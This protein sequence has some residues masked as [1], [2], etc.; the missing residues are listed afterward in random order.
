M[1]HSGSKPTGPWASCPRRYA[2]TCCG[3]GWSQGDREFFSTP[4]MLGAFDLAGVGRSPSRFDFVKLENMNG[5]YLRQTDNRTLVDTLVATLPYLPE[6]PRAS[7]ALD[8]AMRDKLL[9]AMPGLKERA[10]T[11]V[12]LLDGAQFLFATRPLA[13]DAKAEDILGKGGRAVLAGL[14]PA[15]DAVE[16]WTA[17]DIEAVVRS[18]AET[19]GLK[20][21]Q[22]AQ[23]LAGRRDRSRDLRPASSMSSRCSVVMKVSADCMIKAASW[24]FR[25]R[26]G[27][28]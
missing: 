24:P 2:T 7:A 1:A 28:P 22:A 17:P 21:G 23:P 25:D 19:S 6:G 13:L 26:Q 20:L 16:H 14:L 9:A 12:E 8:E 3:L 18:Y 15:L 5:H 11:L 27:L 4:D 10:K